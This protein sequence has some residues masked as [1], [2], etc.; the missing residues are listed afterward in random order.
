MRSYVIDEL[1]PDEV[2]KLAERLEKMELSA[3]MEGLYWL[4]VPPELLLPLQVEHLASCGP[5]ALALEL[6]QDSL[7]LELLTRARNRLRCACVAL[8]TPA[9][10]AHM[11]AWLE[12]LLLELEI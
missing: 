11:I 2:A 4:P 6:G 3:G 10:L 12:S 9:L 1:R 7:R 8:A 5:Y